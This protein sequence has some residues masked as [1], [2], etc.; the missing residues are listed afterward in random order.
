M[1]RELVPVDII[2]TMSSQDWKREIVKCYNQDSGMSP[3]EAKIAFLKVR[4]R[5]L[6]MYTNIYYKLKYRLY[7]K[8]NTDITKK[9]GADIKQDR[10]RH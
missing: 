1:M 8:T 5:K 6:L 9:T 2:K 10:C 7:K 3:E 4:F